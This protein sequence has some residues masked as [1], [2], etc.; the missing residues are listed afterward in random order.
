M[1]GWR[2]YSRSRTDIGRELWIGGPYWTVGPG[3]FSLNDVCAAVPWL[4]IGTCDWRRTWKIECLT[5]IRG[6]RR[7]SCQHM[8]CRSQCDT[9]DSS[10]SLSLDRHFFVIDGARLRFDFW[11]R[12]RYRLLECKLLRLHSSLRQSLFLFAYLFQNAVEPRVVID[13]YWSLS[14][15]C[16]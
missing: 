7:L 9:L 2:S 13:F 1:R 15:A 16:T 6:C 5:G 14:P 4:V 8:S 10:S 12:Y 11:R 3:G